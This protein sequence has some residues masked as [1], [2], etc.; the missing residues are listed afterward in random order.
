[1]LGSR[2]GG[3]SREPK[4]RALGYS[5][6]SRHVTRVAKRGIGTIA[7]G[8]SAR[9]HLD[10]TPARSDPA[11]ISRGGC[12]ARSPARCQR[13]FIGARPFHASG[14]QAV[15]APLHATQHSGR[16]AAASPARCSYRLA[17][18]L[19]RSGR[20]V[21][22]RANR[23]TRPKR[24]RTAAHASNSAASGGSA[25]GAGTPAAVEEPRF[26]RALGCSSGSGRERRHRRHELARLAR[27]SDVGRERPGTP[28]SSPTTVTTSSALVLECVVDGRGLPS[29]AG[30]QCDRAGQAAGAAGRVPGVC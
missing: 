1:M 14:S 16:R 29:R 9:T 22:L 28:P 8:A 24:R 26:R 12:S 6:G 20:R 7:R 18:L 2:H 3:L 4:A 17:P 5:T 30:G 25:R 11:G 23:S 21:L 15:A 19:G 10:R 27:S 13:P